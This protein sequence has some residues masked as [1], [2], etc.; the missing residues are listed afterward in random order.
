MATISTATPPPNVVKLLKKH[1][2]SPS[3]FLWLA[4]PSLNPPQKRLSRTDLVKFHKVDA[5][6]ILSWTFD[7]PILIHS[8]RTSDV[9]TGCDRQCHVCLA[10]SALPSKIFSFE[11]LKRLWKLKEFVATLDV[12]SHRVGS[13]ADV[14]DHPDGPK[15]IK[16]ALTSTRG[17]DGYQIKVFTN[18]RPA[19]E[20]TL[21]ELL[22]LARTYGEKLHL[23]VSL[24]LNMSDVIFNRFTDYMKS[25]TDFFGIETRVYPDGAIGY[26]YSLENVSIMNV[27]HPDG[28]VTSGRILSQ[29]QLRQ[30][31]II[32][33]DPDMD[34]L[35][36][37][38]GLVKTYFNPDGLWLMMYG[39]MFDSYTTRVFTPLTPDNISILSLLPWH[40]YFPT[41][42]NWPGGK[43]VQLNGWEAKRLKAKLYMSGKTPFK[44]KII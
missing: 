27:A 2:F 16:H 37:Q 19:D 24:P 36:T 43:G 35:Y 10:D 20:D 41:P 38:R 11:S 1:G 31:H 15:I 7:N 25:R 40:P 29:S 34:N 44:A 13:S 4:V 18:Y 14:Q 23:T 26:P 32:Y 42:P 17:L 28:L 3:D 33:R 9:V 5:V 22:N 12:Q 6:E 8:S 21:D 30:K 39:T